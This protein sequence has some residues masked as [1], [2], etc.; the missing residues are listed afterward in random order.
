MR[1]QGTSGIGPAGT[2]DRSLWRR[3]QEIEAPS[4][5]AERLLELAALADNRLDDDDD[6]AR[7]AALIADDADLMQDVAAA[8]ALADATMLAAD[9]SVVAR[10]EALV[11]EDRPEA[12]L[13]AFPVHQ[14]IV[15]PW[16]SAATWSGLAAAI[17]IAGWLGF[18]LGSGLSNIPPFGHSPGDVAASE[19]L[20]PGPVL[21]RDFTE[22]S[23]I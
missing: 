15:R 19:L 14:T 6:T 22:N 4:D 17:V 21:L 8:R 11:G 16:Y 12:V 13:I 1:A 5:E 2:P 18:D 9:E 23:Q 3:C 10:A 7:I 20:D